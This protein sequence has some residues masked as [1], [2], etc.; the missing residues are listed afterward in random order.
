MASAYSSDVTFE[1][2]LVFAGAGDERGAGEADLKKGD[3]PLRS[4]EA[5]AAL[6][7]G[8]KL[9]RA[10]LSVTR[11]EE[12]WSGTFDADT[13]AFGSFSVPQG[14]KLDEDD[15]FIERMESVVTFKTA[16][17]EYFKVFVDAMSPE[18][19]AGTE[20]NIREWIRD[21]DAI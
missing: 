1:A 20:K 9:R 16:L 18:K 12:I 21:R 4:A 2:P 11:G 8:K 15:A 3:S 19:R 10:K 17:T 5:K 7:V 14:E 6:G 13:F